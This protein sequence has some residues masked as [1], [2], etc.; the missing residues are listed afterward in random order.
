M[1]VCSSSRR[2]RKNADCWGWLTQAHSTEELNVTPSHWKVIRYYILIEYREY[3]LFPKT[4]NLHPSRTSP[5]LWRDSICSCILF[6]GVLA[7]G[8]SCSCHQTLHFIAGSPSSTTKSLSLCVGLPFLERPDPVFTKLVTSFQVNFLWPCWLVC[9]AIYRLSV[10]LHFLHKIDSTALCHTYFTAEEKR[11]FIIIVYYE[12]S[13]IFQGR[14]RWL[15]KD[16]IIAE[17]FPVLNLL[18][19]LQNLKDQL[20]MFNTETTPTPHHWFSVSLVYHTVKTAI[21]VLWH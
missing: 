2:N 5:T 9:G 6:S 8:C 13:Q 7:D 3:K 10:I 1:L 4:A 11:H 20:S 16:Y 14:K 21:R 18:F 17:V 19:S 15:F 12:Q